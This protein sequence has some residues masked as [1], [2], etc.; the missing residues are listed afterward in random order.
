MLHLKF[1]ICPDMKIRQDEYERR[2]R[3]VL[4]WVE[5]RKKGFEDQNLETH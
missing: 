3:A 4:Q 5:D 1:N 2:A